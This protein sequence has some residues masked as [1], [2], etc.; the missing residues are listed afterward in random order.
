M[1]FKKWNI[2]KGN[3]EL[4]EILAQ[5]CDISQLVAQ[6][7]IN[8]GYTSYNSAQQFIENDNEISSPYD[9]K[10]MRRAADRIRQA[11][12]DY[13]KI[14]VYGDYDCD[15]VTSTAMLY[16]YLSSIGAD[17]MYYIPERDGEGYGLNKEALK[18]LSQ[19]Q[20]NLIITV[21]N[22][23]TAIDET[24]YAKQ[25]GM[26]VVI[27]DH[28]QPLE[29][30]PNA[31]AIVNPHRKDCTSQFKELCGAGVVFKLIAAIEDG[32]FHAALESFADIA[33]VGTI[34][35]IVSLC[36]ENRAIVKYG[37]QMLKIS[38]N[39]GL[40]ALMEIAGIKSEILTAQNVAFGIVP[41]INAAGRMGS[42][43]LAVKLLLCEDYDEAVEIA[44]Q[45]DAF[46]KQRQSDELKILSDIDKMIEN[47]KTI[48]TS[49]VIMLYDPNWNHG[50]IGIVCSKL[51]ERYGKPVML[52]TSE[53]G[54]LKGSARSIGEFH[55]F[56]ALSVNSEHLLQYGGHK[57]AAG[58]SLLEEKFVDLKVGIEDYARQNYDI[59][60]QYCYNIDGVLTIDEMTVENVNSLSVLE[61]FGAKNDMPL[62]LIK[63]CKIDS[64]TSLSNGKHIRLALSLSGQVFSAL[65]FGMTPESFSYKIG[66]VVD[67]I[68]NADINE[69]NGKTSVSVKI[70]DIRS[71]AFVQDKFFAAK[72]YYEKIIKGEQVAKNIILNSIPSREDTAKIYKYL[73]ANGGYNSDIEGIYIIAIQNNINYCKLRIILDILHEVG[74]IC[75]SPILTSISINENVQKVDLNSSKL[76]QRL[77]LFI[78]NKDTI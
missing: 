33:T 75:L 26:E 7:L 22:G 72:G 20:V 27:T 44:Q 11:V 43:S 41:R 65:Y 30:L 31:Y 14:A 19:E 76:L 48:L 56:K 74:L 53:D 62:F 55:L 38:D 67:I 13:E 23:I 28:H 68:F 3:S 39:V 73:K 25:L 60:P 34:A 64:I 57:L 63:N 16:T 36:G 70:K 49:R 51:L 78:Q 59:M 58:F 46:N 24:D 66:D 54:K 21:D 10:D 69:Y 61:P 47:D 9:I 37:L 8:R 71:S 17:V 32:D 1:L 2:P 40:N 50:I 35:D 12:Y 15:G 52:M 77:N 45:L 29:Q 5:E 4:A 6:I 42:A 18:Q